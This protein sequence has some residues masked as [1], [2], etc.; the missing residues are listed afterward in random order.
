VVSDSAE[1]ENFQHKSIKDVLNSD[2]IFDVSDKYIQSLANEIKRYEYILWN[3]P[4]GMFEVDR[5]KTGSK[6]LI[7]IIAENKK[8]I[9]ITGGGESVSLVRSLKMQNEFSFISTAGGAF[10]DFIS[11]KNLPGV[12]CLKS[13][14]SN[15]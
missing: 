15:F 10:L 6:K 4:L 8:A 2:I 14:K 9:K 13:C 3:G 11:N 12:Q 1:N 5:Y 7:Q